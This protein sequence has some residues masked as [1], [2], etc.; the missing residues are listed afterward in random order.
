MISRSGGVRL[1]RA[2]G[3]VE[4]SS[5]LRKTT[6]FA[7]ARRS[8]RQQSQELTRLRIGRELQMDAKMPVKLPQVW[9]GQAGSAGNYYILW[10]ETGV[11]D[12]AAVSTGAGQ[13]GECADSIQWLRPAMRP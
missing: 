8:R 12:P 4:T 6:L 3:T 5:P 7:Y 2:S 9:I 10:P 13:A 11:V 1:Q